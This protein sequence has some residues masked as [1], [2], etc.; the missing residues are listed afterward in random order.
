[1][2]HSA[3]IEHI[4]QALLGAGEILLRHA[5]RPDRE[6][7]RKADGQPVTLADL[8]ADDYLRAT[9]PREGEGWLSEESEDDLVRLERSAV[10]IVDPLDGTKEF[11]H[12]ID[13]WSISIGFCID[14][15]PCAGGIFNPVTDELI[16]GAAGAGVFLGT[17]PSGPSSTQSLD[18]ALVV[19]S[20]NELRRGEWSRFESEPFTIR[21]VGSVAYKLALVACGRADAMWTFLPKNEWDVAAGVALLRAGNGAVWRPDDERLQFNRRHAR[22]PGIVATA[23]RLEQPIR[24]LLG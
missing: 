14:G 10:W 20:R 19:A 4:R 12:G 11:I 5:D 1:M 2:D 13:E 3:T 23:P 7:R 6:I 15:E 16:V 21:G 8:E 24:R 9:L 22:L 18:E 17:E